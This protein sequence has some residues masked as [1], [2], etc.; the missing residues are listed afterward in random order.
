M[1]APLTVRSA[2]VTTKARLRS[3]FRLPFYALSSSESD[4]EQEE[5]R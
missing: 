2:S 5:Q 1:S 4:E 3:S